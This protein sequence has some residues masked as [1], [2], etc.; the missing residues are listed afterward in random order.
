MLAPLLFLS[1]AVAPEAPAMSD[2]QLEQIAQAILAGAAKLGI[3]E[4]IPRPPRPPGKK[5]P[6]APAPP[7]EGAPAPQFPSAAEMQTA[8]AEAMET[9]AILRALAA[10]RKL[11]AVDPVFKLAFENDGV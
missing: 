9:V 8:R 3:A 4:R 6:A 1:L 5:R 10:T 11:E 7:P 2:A